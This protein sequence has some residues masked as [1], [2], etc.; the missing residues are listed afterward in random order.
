MRPALVSATKTSPFGA[1][2]IWRGPLNPS[3]NSSAL[4]PAGTRG[5]ADGGRGTTRE[6]FEAEA[7]AP[8]LGKSAGR[9]SLTTPGLSE[10]QSPNAA[11]PVSGPFCAD[12]WPNTEKIA[13][14][15][16][17]HRCI[18]CMIPRLSPSSAKTV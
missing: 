15:A 2:R 8:G 6:L 17:A 4:K 9:I 18:D 13:A 1:T 7:V 5:A 11:S 12:A 16:Q 14:L 3:A 10:R